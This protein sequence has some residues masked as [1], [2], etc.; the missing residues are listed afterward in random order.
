MVRHGLD[1]RIEQC[2]LSYNPLRGT[3]RGLH[4]QAAPHEETKIV[5]CVRGSIYDVVLDLREGEAFGA[6]ESVVLTGLNRRAI[7]VPRGVAH[8]FMTLEN[9]CEIHYTMSQ[10]YHPESARGVAWN[11]PLFGIEWPITL[12]IL[13]ETDRT[14]PLMGSIA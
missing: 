6:W 9:D 14:R 1:G 3:L 7:Y 2:S 10:A 4:Y 12:P 5:R 13:S 11:D 8:G